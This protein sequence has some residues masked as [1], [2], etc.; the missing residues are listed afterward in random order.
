MYSTQINEESKYAFKYGLDL[1]S[2]THLVYRA[3]V[4]AITDTDAK[5]A[6]GAL[7]DVIERRVNV[8]GV[9]EPIVQVERGGFGGEKE[10]R[11]IVELPGITDVDE[12]VALIG[13]TPL[14]EFKLAT[15]SSTEFVDDGNGNMIPDVSFV[16]TG[17][18]GRYLKRAQLSFS[19]AQGGVGISEPIVLIEFNKEG[20]ELFA[21]IT[22]NNVGNVLAI[23]LDGEAISVPVIQSE[24]TDGSAQISGDFEAEEARTLV[25]DLNLGA[26]PVPIELIST[27]SI[28]ASLGHD[29]L[30][31]G[32]NAALIG[33]FI[34]S[35][36]LILWYR[37]PGVISVVS[38]S[39]YLVMMLALFKLIPVVLTA[40]GIA[41]FIL[42]IGMAV[43][44]NVLI[45]ERVKEELEERNDLQEAIK[46]GFSRAWLSI[47]DG[48]ISS[49]ITAIILFWAGTSMV[50]G[51][52][53]TF[54]LGV[55]ISMISAIAVSRTFTLAIAGESYGGLKKFLFGHGLR[56]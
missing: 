41:G 34:L 1:S 27:Q 50:K 28:G 44:A 17:L 56:K 12:A 37:L 46:Q 7:R 11:L 5:G 2:G 47:R 45:F 10:E 3:D 55:L 51:F 14:L 25:R 15:Q 39:I 54:G 35:L 19:G 21:D 20:A 53:L 43:D 9:S 4:S 18:T 30:T 49:I 24:I 36:F 32:V 8:F 40:A 48:N 33:L 38:L 22:K 26:L 42:S 23:F 31:S 16:D 29:A 13:K 6:M 52:A